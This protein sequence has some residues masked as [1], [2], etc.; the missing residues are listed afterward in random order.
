M[1][2][3]SADPAA[4][5]PG[6]GLDELHRAVLDLERR[7]WQRGGQK[8]LAIRERFGMSPARYY[9]VLN[10]LLDSP[11]ALR[12]DPLLV[13]RLRRLRD[14]RAHARSSRSFGATPDDAD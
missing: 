2:A 11:A 5:A 14:A 6:D 12:H 4:A 10:G 3:A 13:G 8:E 7:W 1:P 9:Q